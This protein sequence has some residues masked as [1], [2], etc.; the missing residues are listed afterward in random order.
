MCNDKWKSEDGLRIHFIEHHSAGDM[1]DYIL[2]QLKNLENL[3]VV[4]K[5]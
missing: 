2:E 4:L 1:A 5:E 3:V